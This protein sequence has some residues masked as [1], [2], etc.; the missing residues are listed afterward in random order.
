MA[1]SVKGIKRIVVQQSF[2]EPV[3]TAILCSRYANVDEIGRSQQGETQNNSDRTNPVSSEVHASDP[4]QAVVICDFRLN[5]DRPDSGSVRYK[6]S[7]W[8][9]LDRF[10]GVSEQHFGSGCSPEKVTKVLT[11]EILRSAKAFLWH[12][13]WIQQRRD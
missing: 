13:D 6:Y 5:Q 1:Y 2:Q 3:G 11:R 12:K 4:R 9:G 7:E 8:Y 10:K